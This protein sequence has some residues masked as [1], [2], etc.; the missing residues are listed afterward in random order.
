M[1]KRGVALIVGAALLFAAA[2][3]TAI[4]IDLAVVLGNSGYE[5]GTT[6][7]W[8]TT[9]PNAMYI[10]NVPV[11]PAI[12]P[13]DPCCGDGTLLPAL[14]APVGDHFV[15][16]VNGTLMN[17]L[18]GKLAHDALGQSFAADTIFQ[19][20]VWAN[21]GRLDTNGNLNSTFGGAPPTMNVQLR[22]WTGATAP[23]VT[24]ATDN[25]VPGPA[26]TNTQM[27]TDWGTPGQWTSQ[28]F[29]WTPGTA[30][31]YISL[32]IAG[33]NHNHDQYVAWDLAPIPEPSTGLLLGLG[34]LG[35]AAGRRFPRA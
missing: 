33:L 30:F 11:D 8:T 19:V 18:N 35:L 27:F 24:A 4:T 12:S 7:Q 15:G 13:L 22:G 25:W 32:G 9:R 14:T 6:G 23:T 28:T 34:L 1:R 16:V 20:V 26:Y 29:T 17:D 3:A 21:R 5:D 10:V 31:Q 2:P